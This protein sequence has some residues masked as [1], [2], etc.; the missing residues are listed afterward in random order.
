VP[1]GDR[2]SAAGDQEYG[3]RLR[4]LKAW[5]EVR[6]LPKHDCHKIAASFKAQNKTNTAF[7]ESEILSEL[8][9]S[10]SATVM[11]YLYNDYLAVKRIRVRSLQRHAC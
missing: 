8:P 9:P 1:P 4:A 2:G 7:N 5:M 11:R 3:Q 10:L 6:K